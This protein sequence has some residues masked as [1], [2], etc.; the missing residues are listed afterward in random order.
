MATQDSGPSQ[1]SHYRAVIITTTTS[2][3]GGRRKKHSTVF[4]KAEHETLVQPGIQRSNSSAWLVKYLTRES[5]GTWLLLL[6]LAA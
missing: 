6:L 3:I 2:T 4:S 5:V 1:L